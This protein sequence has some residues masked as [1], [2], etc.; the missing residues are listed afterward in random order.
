MRP[1]RRFPFRF[2]PPPLRVQVPIQIVL[3]IG[4]DV[5]CYLRYQRSAHVETW[6]VPFALL[7]TL[8]S[9]TAMLAALRFFPRDSKSSH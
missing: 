6:L 2:T 5:L 8:L 7:V 1:S 3:T 9:L 4:L